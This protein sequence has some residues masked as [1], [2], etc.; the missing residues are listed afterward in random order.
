MKNFIHLVRHCEATGQE[1]DAPL[2]EMG[3]RQAVDLADHLDHNPIVLIISSPY[4]RAVQSI[5]PLAERLG[6]LIETDGRLVE[7]VLCGTPLP[8]WRERLEESFLDLDL[9]LPGG[10]SSR[11]AM[12]RAVA[13]VEAI[14]KE[15]G[16]DVLI[17]THGNLLTLIMKHFEEHFGYADWERM[18]TPEAFRLWEMEGRPYIDRMVP[19]EPYGMSEDALSFEV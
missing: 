5:T 8:D 16:R 15:P 2:T 3:L 18:G 13:V 14:E 9:C 19:D 7:R 4:T 1:P 10:E 11:A 17:V 12:T 6:I